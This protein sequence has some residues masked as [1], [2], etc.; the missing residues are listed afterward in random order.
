MYKIF[1]SI[2]YFGYVEWYVKLVSG[3]FWAVADLKYSRMAPSWL[4]CLFYLYVVVI[5]HL[6][7]VMLVYKMMVD[8]FITEPAREEEDRKKRIEAEK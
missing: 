8:H 1:Q 6:V 3:W 4:W 2:D 7:S 5:P